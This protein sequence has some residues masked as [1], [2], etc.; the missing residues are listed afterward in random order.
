MQMVPLLLQVAQD[1]GVPSSATRTLAQELSRSASSIWSRTE[2]ARGSAPRTTRRCSSSTIRGTHRRLG[3]GAFLAQAGAFGSSVSIND[4]NLG[5][6]YY[7]KTAALIA[8][9]DPTWGNLGNMGSIHIDLMALNEVADP[10]RDNLD[11]QFLFPFL[12]NFDV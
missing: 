3:R 10:D 4:Q 1:P 2:S 7:L 11:T 6:G 12:R 8:Q 5:F 9:Y